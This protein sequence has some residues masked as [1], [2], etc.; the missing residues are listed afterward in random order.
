MNIDA[1]EIKIKFE[2]TI[3]EQR[4]VVCQSLQSLFYTFTNVALSF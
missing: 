3:A 2:T 1:V 4:L